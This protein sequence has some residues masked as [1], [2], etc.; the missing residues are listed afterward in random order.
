MNFKFNNPYDTKDVF[1]YLSTLKD[2]KTHNLILL[3]LQTYKETD[4]YFYCICSDWNIYIDK[5]KTYDGKHYRYIVNF[6]NIIPGK[7][8]YSIGLNDEE[9]SN[10][11]NVVKNKIIRR[12]KK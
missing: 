11:M 5:N 4:D 3:S 12:S 8:R 6:V 9:Y 2:N 1:N 7:T 10:L